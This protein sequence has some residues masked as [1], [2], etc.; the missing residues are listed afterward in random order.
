[1]HVRRPDALIVSP[2]VHSRVVALA[3]LHWLRAGR[4]PQDGVRAVQTHGT[5]FARPA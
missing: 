5:V 4:R 3:S 2:P 1:M